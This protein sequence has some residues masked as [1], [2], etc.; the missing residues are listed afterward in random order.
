MSK[1]ILFIIS[2]DWYF[3]THR[4]HLAVS[5]IQSGYKVAL[6]SR[7]TKHRNEVENA[8]IKAIHWTLNRSSK[9]PF[10]EWSA[11]LGIVSAIRQFKPDL[12]H[13]VAMKPVIYSAFASQLYRIK[14]RVFTLAGLGYIFSSETRLARFLR[15]AIKF[16]FRLLFIGKQTRLILQNPENIA[17]L[18]SARTINKNSFRLIRGAGVDINLFSSTPIPS[19]IPIVILPSRMLWA[20][21]IRDFIDCA[22][23]VN[24]N[25]VK[26]RFVLV[27]APD[28]L[29]PD[30]IPAEQLRTWDH[31]GIVEWWGHR[32]EMQHVFQQSTIVCLPTSYGEG[33]PKTLLEAASCGR[34]IVTY[35]VPGCR[36]VVINQ[37][38]GFLVPLKDKDAM[39]KA[40]ETLM[41]DRE[42]CSQM[43]KKGRELVI[44]EF[45]QEQIAAETIAVWKEILS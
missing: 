28:A 23:F 32:D 44:K 24:I 36:E 16:T 27:G 39:I 38:N 9:N 6:L 2:E 26:A 29:N 7:Y 4:L 8:G 17:T 42:L 35:D 45:S 34:P 11:I 13:S 5:A 3:V 31:E 33:L 40:I 15:P 21:G 25:G 20:K 12:I 37:V 1:N 10:Q 22:R 14:P 43:G 18:L 19:D 41:E 30:A